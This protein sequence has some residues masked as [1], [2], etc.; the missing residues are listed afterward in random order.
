[1]TMTILTHDGTMGLSFSPPH[2]PVIGEDEAVLL[3]VWRTAVAGRVA[4]LRATLALLVSDSM[5]GAA[6]RA[7]A[8]AATA[9]REAGLTLAP[10]TAG[11]EGR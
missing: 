11:R 8:A 3:S 5:A 10:A 6:A 7:C 4:Q 1:M 9:L 2:H